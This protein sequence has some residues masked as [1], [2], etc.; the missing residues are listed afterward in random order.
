M[1]KLINFFRNNKN[2]LGRLQSLQDSLLQLQAEKELLADNYHL[3]IKAVN[4]DDFSCKPELENNP[5]AGSGYIESLADIK[6]K[7]RKLNKE[8][9]FLKSLESVSKVLNLEAKAKAIDLIKSLYKQGK[10]PLEVYNETISSKTDKGQTR[11]ADVMVLNTKGE[12]LLLKRSIWEDEHKGA[13]VIPGGHVDEGE[14]DTAAAERE[15]YEESGISVEKL[16]SNDQLGTISWN[17]VGVYEND[18]AHICYYLLSGVDTR[19]FEILLDEAETRDYLWVPKNEIKNYP[20][21]F[22]MQHNVI[23]LLGL[24]DY[25]QELLIQ[26][27]IEIIYK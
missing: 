10:L 15:L 17:K 24:D 20:M 6:L 23:A 13:W 3:I 27:S 5:L 18:K 22:S 14:D 8:I 2:K 9:T 19:D 4:C 11:Y 16:K 12:L 25:P 21:I 26:K 1:Y 7:E